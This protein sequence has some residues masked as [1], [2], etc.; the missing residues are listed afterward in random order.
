MHS[1][2]AFDDFLPFITKVNDIHWTPV[3]QIK[4]QQVYNVV[5]QLVAI[6]TVLKTFRDIYLGGFFA[7]Q[8]HGRQNVSNQILTTC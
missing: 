2:C 8:T 5:N 7:M 6:I 4:A 3:N 1:S